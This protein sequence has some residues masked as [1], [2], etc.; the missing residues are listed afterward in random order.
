MRH[1]NEVSERVEALLDSG[2][3]PVDICGP[4]VAAE[5][6]GKLNADYVVCGELI[7]YAPEKQA[8]SSSFLVFSGGETNTMFDCTGSQ[9]ATLV[10]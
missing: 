2:Y 3:D 6:G 1:L 7:H 5:L 10:C 8:T 9:T 4:V